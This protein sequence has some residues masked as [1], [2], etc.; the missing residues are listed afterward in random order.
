MVYEGVTRTK[1]FL[2]NEGE[3]VYVIPDQNLD[4]N[5]MVV[6]V[7]ESFDSTNGSIVYSEHQ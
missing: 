4:V 2:A 5:S 3:S 1:T 6:E 7:F